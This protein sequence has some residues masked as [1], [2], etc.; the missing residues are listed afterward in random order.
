M[1]IKFKQISSSNITELLLAFRRKINT[2]A[3]N[4]SFGRELTFAQIEILTF[5]GPKD[6]KTMESIATY[7][8]IAPPSATSLI[9]KMEKIGLVVRKKDKNDRRVVYIELSSKTK[10]E[11][12]SLW[13]KK[14]AALNKVVSKL[15]KADR[16][17]L[18]RIIKILVTD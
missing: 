14:A 9:E 15:T 8:K 13:K 16:E 2:C 6:M 17:H 7:L 18:E 11:I 4:V 12:S 3:K 10:K 5:I 1:P